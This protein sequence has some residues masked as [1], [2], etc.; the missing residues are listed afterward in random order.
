MMLTLAWFVVLDSL[1]CDCTW[2]CLQHEYSEAAASRLAADRLQNN[3]QSTCKFCSDSLGTSTRF[4]GDA[5]T[6]QKP[7]LQRVGN[8]RM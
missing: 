8:L 1:R 7:S 4:I 2:L 5:L 6:V 3:L